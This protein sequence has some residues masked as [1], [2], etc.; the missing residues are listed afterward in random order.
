MLESSKE[1]LALFEKFN[2]SELNYTDYA[3][4]DNY[5]SAIKELESLGKIRVDNSV[6]GKITKI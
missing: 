6:T 2:D 5:K 3:V 4:I 1:L